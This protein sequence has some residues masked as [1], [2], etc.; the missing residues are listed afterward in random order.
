M[1]F[2]ATRNYALKKLD[3]FIEK[4]LLEYAKLRNFDFGIKKRNNI[5]CLSPYI[6]HGIINEEE[7]IS[8]VLKKYLF[9]KSEKFIQEVLWRIYW[10]G[11]LELRPDVW[12]DY[13]INLRSLKEKYKTDKRYLN[14]IEGNTTIL[15]FNDWVKELKNTNYLHNHARMWFA[16]IWTFT[17]DLPWELGAEFFLKHLYDGDPASNTLGWR[18]VVG[19]Q[20]QGKHYLASEWNIRKFTDN[21]YEKIKLSENATSKVSSKIYSI[22]KKN[23]L[24]SEIIDNKILLIFDNNLS[25]DFS[26]F[27]DNKFKK[28]YIVNSCENRKISLSNNVM[29]FKDSLLKDQLERI[30]KLSIDCEIIKI[31]GIKKFSEDIY[32]LYPSIGENLDFINKYKM[33]NIQ[34]LYRKI[35]QLSWQY[36]TKG[37]FNF[38]KYIPKIVQSIS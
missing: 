32:A 20:T 8:K 29:K 14:A 30:K 22:S 9:I 13:L 15:C 5:S 23:F 19:I 33:K 35:D 26:D 10:K 17:L 3:D 34:F 16:S 2:I 27:K 1:N 28:I 18:W 24:N 37:F 7:I 21:R 38:K 12:N 6:S 25:Y 36:C 31:E 11:W 4:N